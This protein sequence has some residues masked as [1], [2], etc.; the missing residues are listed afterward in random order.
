[1]SPPQFIDATVKVGWV[2][3]RLDELLGID[4]AERQADPEG[5]TIREAI[6]SLKTDIVTSGN[7]GITVSNGIILPPPLKSSRL[8]DYFK[9]FTSGEMTLTRLTSYFGLQI[10]SRRELMRKE[11]KLDREFST[12]PIPPQLGLIPC[13]FLAARFTTVTG[14]TCEY[15]NLVRFEA[16]PA[17]NDPKGDP[18]HNPQAPKKARISRELPCRLLPDVD[19]SVTLVDTKANAQMTIT[20][21]ADWVF[22]VSPGD[23]LSYFGCITVVQSMEFSSAE[24][25]LIANLC[26]VSGSQ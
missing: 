23:V 15:Q 10:P 1:M 25:S 13:Y 20:G 3:S 14:L 24:T 9:K 4:A 7:L 22:G 8:T 16:R 18:T 26:I 12:R 2:V 17:P 19:L 6:Q 21:R 11:L 5:A